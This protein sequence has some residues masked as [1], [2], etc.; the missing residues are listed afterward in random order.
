MS[1]LFSRIT[2]R[3]QAGEAVVLCRIIDASGSTPRGAGARMAVFQDG[4]TA[5]TIGGGAVEL[6]ASQIGRELCEEGGSRTCSFRLTPGDIEDIGMICGGDVTLLFQYLSPD[7]LPL[8]REILAAM[9]SGGPSWLVTDLWEDGRWEM[10][11]DK[12]GDGPLFTRRTMLREGEPRRYVEPL[13]PAGCVYIFGA[14][15]VGNAL[16]RLLHWIGFQVTVFDD[17]PH[18]LKEELFPEGV[19]RI[20]GDY[21]HIDFPLTREDCAVVMSPGHKMDYQILEQVLRTDAGYIGCIGSRRKVAATRE[22]LLKAGFSQEV[23]D[24]IHSPIGLP[25]GGETPEEIAVSVAAELIA[26]RS[27]KLSRHA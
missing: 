5:G 27:G 19:R 14:G 2:D 4:S 1:G 6:R 17:R 3:L 8:V 15:H 9:E 26:H 25:I 20:L 24:A 11:L 10:T 21:A 22:L 18:A 13:C 7:Q 16:A 23:I 12:A